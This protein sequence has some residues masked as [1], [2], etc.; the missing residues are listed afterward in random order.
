MPF[1]RTT[2][3]VNLAVDQEKRLR[4]GTAEL[5]RD[6][7]NK[8]PIRMMT[9]YEG[10]IHLCRG[11]DDRRNVPTA[12]VECKFLAAADMRCLRPLTRRCMNFTEMYCLFSR[13]ICISSTRLFM[14]GMNRQRFL[15]YN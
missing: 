2:T 1:I 4:T 5:V 7:L 14:A 12:F 10:N 8:D 9:A 3:N 11:G 15:K 6:I 13:R